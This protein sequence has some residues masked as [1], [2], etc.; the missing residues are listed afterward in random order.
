MKTGLPEKINYS[1]TYVC[2]VSHNPISTHIYE[3]STHIR[4]TLTHINVYA[5][6]VYITIESIC[7]PYA[8]KWKIG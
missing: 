1:I 2:D 3:H 7:V 8:S 4:V 5:L 6:Q